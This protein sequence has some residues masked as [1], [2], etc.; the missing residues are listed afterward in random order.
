MGYYEQKNRF[1]SYGRL[2]AASGLR[3]KKQEKYA[4]IIKEYVSITGRYLT[5]RII[6]LLSCKKLSGGNQLLCWHLTI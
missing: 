5:I 4:I 3:L 6:G 2:Q 1:Y